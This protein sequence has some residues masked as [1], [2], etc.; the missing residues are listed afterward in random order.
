MDA[1]AAGELG[2]VTGLLP[3]LVIWSESWREAR[4]EILSK[5]TGKCKHLKKSD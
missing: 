3:A 2:P 1:V 5:H 4:T